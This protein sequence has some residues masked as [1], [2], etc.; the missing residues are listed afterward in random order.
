M[1]ERTF[2]LFFFFLNKPQELFKLL[3]NRFE[4]IITSFFFLFERKTTG[5]IYEAFIFRT[6]YESGTLGWNSFRLQ[7]RELYSG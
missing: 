1:K 5:T 2:T 4:A 3:D 7:T 6:K